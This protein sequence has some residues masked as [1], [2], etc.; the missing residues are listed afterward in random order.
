MGR[1]TG[2]GMG[3]PHSWPQIG[4]PAPSRPLQTC[5]DPS[6]PEFPQ[7]SQL[8]GFLREPPLSRGPPRT[9]PV[10]AAAPPRF[11]RHEPR[12]GGSHAHSLPSPRPF[13]PPPAMAPGRSPRL[14]PSGSSSGSSSGRTR[15]S[16]ARSSS[17]GSP[18]SPEFPDDA[19]SGSD[20]EVSPRP[21]SKRGPPQG[22]TRS[23]V[24][25]RSR[26]AGD[27][28][29]ELEQNSLFQAV[30]SGKAAME[31]VVDEWLGWY[32]RDQ[33][34]AFLE[35][36]NFIV[37]S[38]GCRGAVTPAMFR[39]L[40]NSEIIRRLTETFDEAAPAYPLARRSPAWRRFRAGFSEL[41]E[42][43]ALRGRH[44]ELR[45]GLV[46]EALP[47][48]LA[49]LAD[50]RVRACRHAATL[51]ALKLMSSLV[52]VA[53]DVGL[54]LE[55]CRRQLEAE[56]GKEPGRRGTEKLELLREQQ[57]ELR[58]RQ[59]ELEELMNGIF[60]GV[61][62]HRYRDVVPEIRGICLEELG[63]W[64]RKFPGSFLTD[65]HLKYLGW[66][67]HDKH[68]AVR[69][70][71]ARALRGLYG[72]PGSGPGLELFTERFK[73]SGGGAVGGGLPE[74]L[75]RGFR[76]QP[77]PGHGCRRIPVPEAPGSPKTR[78]RARRQP[79]LL[80]APRRLL[81][82]LRAPRSR[83]LPGG[84]PVGLRR[85]PP[86]GLGHGRGNA[87]GAGRRWARGTGGTGTNWDGLGWNGMDWEWIGNGLGWTG[88]DWE[89]TGM[90]WDGLGHGRGNAA[91]AG[92]RWARGTGTD[93]DKLGMDWEWTGNG[94]GWTG[95]NWD[96]LG[97]TGMDW[98]WTG[99]R[100]REC[101]WRRAPVGTGD[102]DKL[103]WTGNGLGQTGMDWDKLGWTGTRPRECCW[104]RAP[105]GTGGLGGLGWTGTNWD[106][107]GWTGMDWDTAAGMLLAPGAGGHGGDWDGLGWTG[108]N[109]EWTGNGLGMDWD[110]LGHG[111]G[112]AAGAGRRWARGTGNGLG[113]TGMD[114][115]K[116]GW[117]GTNWD[118]LGWTGTNWDG[119][120]MDWDKLGWT[121]TRPR[122]CCWRRA[123]VGTGGLGWTG[124]NWEWTGNG[125]GMDWDGLGWTGTRPRECCWRRAPVGTG[126][127]GQTGMDWEW[128]GTNWDGLGWT[129]TNWDGLG[130]GRGNAAGAGRRWARGT[131]NG[132]GQTGNGL[133]WTGTN[134]E[135]TG[136]DWDK[137]GQTGMDWE[138]TGTRPRECCW[139]RAPVGTGGLGWTGTNWDGLGQTGMDWDKLGWTGTRP[140]EC[141]WRRAPVG[142]GGLGRTGTNWD[143]LGQTGMDWDKLGWTG[144][145]WD[146]LGM[147]WE[148]IGMDWDTAAGMLLAPGA[149]GHGGTGNG[150]GQTGN[151]LG[152]TGTNW[153][154][155]GWTGTNWEW[156]G[157]DWDGLGMDW[158]KL[159]WTGNGLGM[160]WEWIGMD[161][162][163]L[164]WTGTRPR[165][166][167]WRR[168]PVGT[169]DWEWTGTNWEWTGMDW[170][171]LGQTGM[172]WD[173]LG[174]DWDGL[175]WT[176]NGLGQTGMDWEWTGNG[177]GMDWDGLG[178]T[179]MDWDTAAGMLLAP[180]AGLDLGQEQALVEI[181]SCSGLRLCR[182]RPP[183]G[184][185]QGRKVSSREQR[186][187]RSRLSRSLIPVLPQLLEK[188]SRF[189]PQT[190]V[191]SGARGGGG[192]AG[193]AAAPGAGD[194]P[195]GAVGE[196]PGAAAGADP[197]DFRE[198]LGALPGAP[199]LSQF[200]PVCPSLSQ[201]IP[202]CPSL[203]QFI[204]VCPSPSQFVPVCP[205]VRSQCLEQL[206]GRIQEIFG[207]HSEPSPVLPVC[208]SLS[209]FVPVYPS[210]S[211]CVPVCPSVSQCVP[212]SVPSA[213]SSCWGGSRRF[214][215]STR[216]PPRCSQFVPVCPSLS[217]FI[218]VHPS[219]SQCVPVSV[220]S[221]WSS[222][223]G[224]SR[225]FS[226]ST[227]SPPRCSRRP[228][229][230]CARS[231]TPRCPC[232]ASGT[233][234]GGAWGTAWGTGA[235]CR[236]PRCSR[237]CPRTRRTFTGW[238]PP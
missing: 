29:K 136:M 177:L 209:Q 75:P 23:H 125:L 194:V 237:R 34:P 174:M 114:W 63:K 38:C 119:L 88:M 182:G 236:S 140:R 28:G 232:T 32:R 214:S 162:D 64:V 141:C 43:L 172:D 27:A 22:A 159:G 149:G 96:G 195:H 130:H 115:D 101:C 219:V 208:P 192:A 133:G 235:T 94:L 139:R 196:V 10:P 79:Q 50:S 186:E 40:P 216:S 7:N 53:L 42:L 36:L 111:R 238:R 153:D 231:V 193:A 199:S 221:A 146:G 105:V 21:R 154:K 113:Q 19:D 128:T 169:G 59:Q 131:G 85:E 95:T 207:K 205:G 82:R 15:G 68:G 90:D 126:G 2:A 18:H 106:G 180:G 98:E 3:N 127:L 160:D 99:T 5:S 145:D 92:R 76:L 54:Q 224:G 46:P 220:P 66:T 17:P 222:C 164:G 41:L 138:W 170:D 116:L 123:P 31:T 171:K 179:G 81:P 129:G 103:G 12:D 165:E 155:L 67:L 51:A 156:T 212:V 175:G 71:C 181:L 11:W 1:G 30:F 104:H 223:W 142:T 234:P 44:R 161:W 20:F 24:P 230:R 176:G 135:W 229:G 157:T 25:K 57:R 112:N 132:L 197:G 83:R 227:R 217:Q 218:P 211:Q 26:L 173:K 16:G 91:G 69:L 48:F 8:S 147:D 110:G 228:R 124:T 73:E 143:G 178:W 150:L 203:S 163:G 52:E 62:V 215:G 100:P 210:L 108:T 226:G 120:G 61:F 188:N 77:R 189:S 190:P 102:W 45:A 13:R 183:V 14:H 60:K 121:G 200:V 202:V 56:Q 86:A 198:A 213:W 184:R 107:L 151:G 87:A 233:S 109:W 144:M 9:P 39:E 201:F 168:A 187:E 65:S 134:W 137:L 166:C 55:N 47:P 49:G 37:A 6:A 148:W 152:W 74:H 225:R 185:A 93:W 204:P 70:R 122:E 191:L 33:E 89:W 35:L 167:C 72:A 4:N 78:G 206:L 118:R 97:Q 158:D 117:T 84:F 80:P 58:E